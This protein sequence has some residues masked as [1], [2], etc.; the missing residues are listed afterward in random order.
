MLGPFKRKK[1]DGTR[2]ERCTL[3]WSTLKFQRCFLR[4]ITGDDVSRA[5]NG[6][7]NAEKCIQGNCCNDVIQIIVVR[8]LSKF[9]VVTMR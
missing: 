7:T 5:T 3:C 6:I 1:T 2:L 8:M 4:H 9:T